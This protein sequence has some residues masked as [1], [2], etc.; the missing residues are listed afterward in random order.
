MNDPWSGSAFQI[1]IQMTNCMQNH[2][3]PDSKHWLVWWTSSTNRHPFTSG[4]T[5]PLESRKGIWR[6]AR[7]NWKAASLRTSRQP[8][9]MWTKV[10]KSGLLWNF[11]G[12]IK[13]QNFFCNQFFEVQFILPVN[14][15]LI[16]SPDK[17]DLLRKFF[18][19]KYI[20]LKNM[21]KR[22]LNKFAGIYSL[23]RIQSGTFEKARSGT[24]PKWTGLPTL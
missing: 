7:V 19:V 13:I 21:Y 5:P 6:V 16:E 11:K 22:K 24:G 14:Y 20:P 4:A 9:K 3:D 18:K 1:R 8:V 2:A 17:S 10:P 12:L 23:I 15:Q